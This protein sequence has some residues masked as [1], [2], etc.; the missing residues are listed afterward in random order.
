MV[1]ALPAG[2]GARSPLALIPQ[3]IRKRSSGRKALSSDKGGQITPLDITETPIGEGLQQPPFQTSEKSREQN[4]QKQWHKEEQGGR[5]LAVIINGGNGN[6]LGNGPPPSGNGTSSGNGNGKGKEKKR[7]KAAKGGGVDWGKVGHYAKEAAIYG[8]GAGYGRMR[9]REWKEEGDLAEPR[10]QKMAGRILGGIKEDLSETSYYT[11]LGVKSNASPEEINKAFR[12]RAA[13]LHPDVNPSQEAADAFKWVNEANQVLSDPAKRAAYDRAQAEKQASRGTGK[14]WKD[15]PG[16]YRRKFRGQARKQ[17]RTEADVFSEAQKLG[18]PLEQSILKKWD[19]LSEAE[20]SQ[21]REGTGMNPGQD[22]K[23][24]QKQMTF[25]VG[26]R[27]KS[28]AQLTQEIE[29]HK[30]TVA[31]LKAKKGVAET[32]AKEADPDKRKK[33][34]QY[35]G[36]G[37]QIIG[38]IQSKAGSSPIGRHLGTSQRDPSASLRSAGLGGSQL[39]GAIGSAPKL[40]TVQSQGRLTRASGPAAVKRSPF[41]TG[42]MIPAGRVPIKGSGRKQI[43]SKF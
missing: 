2:S 35:A 11:I 30:G 27:L 38:D 42:R 8:S 23:G 4:F 20:K 31:T 17:L 32:M 14:E 43:R 39:R 1:K 15:L 13:V 26:S 12:A 19:Q 9:Y 41:V 40:K 36:R 24:Q 33:A 34:T 16:S 18:I 25:P 21:V 22:P 6:G 5:D 37:L 3:P 28:V 7:R 10:A 29:A